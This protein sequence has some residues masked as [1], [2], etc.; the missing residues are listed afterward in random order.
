[1]KKPQYLSWQIQSLSIYEIL[2]F[3]TGLLMNNFP[4]VLLIDNQTF[5]RNGLVDQFNEHLPDACVKTAA[6]L[7]VALSILKQYRIDLVLTEMLDGIEAGTNIVGLIRAA[8]PTV[9][10]LLYSGYDE[11]VFA[12]LFLR[13]GAMGFLSKRAHWDQTLEAIQTVLAGQKF[14]SVALQMKLLRKRSLRNS[15]L[16]TARSLSDRENTVMQ[17]LLQGKS[18]KEIACMLKLKENAIRTFKHRIFK[19]L[20]VRSPVQLYY[21]KASQFHQP[22][23]S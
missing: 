9:K 19:K 14:I 1:M 3:S 2:R 22:V 20:G 21:L 10:I 8:A 5:L 15:S 13:A 6:C 17:L 4:A 7:E 11:E 18:I 12:P 23:K 16:Q